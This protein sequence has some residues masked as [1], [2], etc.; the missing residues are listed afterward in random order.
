MAVKLDWYDEQHNAVIYRVEGDWEWA[1]LR[2]TV[3]TMHNLADTVHGNIV[4]VIDISKTKKL[5][6]GNTVVHGQYMI[7]NLSPNI[8][9]IVVIIESALIKTFMTMIFGMMPAWRNRLQFVRT[10][11]EAEPLIAKLVQQNASTMMG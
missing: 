5:P 9:H 1:E 2:D 7:Q 10:V 3:G 8:S 11:A 6:S 4:M